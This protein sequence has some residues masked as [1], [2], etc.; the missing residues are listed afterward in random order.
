[1]K[2]SKKAILILTG[3]LV[4][5]LVFGCKS[6]P[7]TL[8][9]DINVPKF[10]SNPPSSDQYLYGVGSAKF[11]NNSSQAMQA[12]DARAR[13][14]LATKLST[15]VQAMIIDY[16]RI[17]GTENN[18]TANLTFYE[19]IS[20]QLTNTT[21]RGVELVERDRTTDGTYWSLVRMSKTDAAQVSAEI[22]DS[23]AS[24]YA[25]FKAME[26][27]KMMEAQLDKK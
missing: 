11:S 21:L 20:R 14:D 8:E 19:S 16:S 1:M 4:A 2:F 23:E 22:I 5:L 24:K 12:A 13:T 10:V 18:S 17:A 27:L 9:T 3:L 7:D 15:E 25:E 26:A 6:K